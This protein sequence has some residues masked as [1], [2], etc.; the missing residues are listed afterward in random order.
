[1]RKQWIAYMLS[2][3]SVFYLIIIPNLIKIYGMDHI[4]AHLNT[5]TSCHICMN[6]TQSILNVTIN[7]AS[8]KESLSSDSM[9]LHNLPAN[10]NTMRFGLSHEATKKH[11]NKQ[12]NSCRDLLVFAAFFFLK[13][14]TFSQCIEKH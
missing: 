4:I 3:R 6:P 10:Y 7:K 13:I 14:K 9:I 8:H 2:S 12:I 5:F 11:M 1:M